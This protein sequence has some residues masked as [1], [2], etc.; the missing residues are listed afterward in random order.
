MRSCTLVSLGIF[1]VR[2][3]CIIVR[4]AVMI[5]AMLTWAHA[6]Y[7]PAHARHIAAQHSFE[8][9]IAHAMQ[10]HTCAYVQQ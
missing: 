7:R 8:D 9:T 2:H 4:Y 3:A 6:P 10:P 1:A 5:D